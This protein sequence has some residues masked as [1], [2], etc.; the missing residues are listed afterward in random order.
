MRFE[1]I[2][3]SI[4]KKIIIAITKAFYEQGNKYLWKYSVIRKIRS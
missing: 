4:R 3:F 2:W 1:P